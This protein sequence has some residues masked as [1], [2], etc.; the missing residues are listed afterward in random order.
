[1]ELILNDFKPYFRKSYGFLRNLFD[2]FESVEINEIGHDDERCWLNITTDLGDFNFS[3]ATDCNFSKF[4]S[5]KFIEI[6]SILQ[7][8]IRGLV[9]EVIEE[10]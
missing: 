9:S 3:T 5:E 10:L 8:D 4:K 7:D 2:G 6:L 1:M